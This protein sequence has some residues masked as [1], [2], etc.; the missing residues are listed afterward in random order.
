M[1]AAGLT[2]TLYMRK[3]CHL[4]EQAKADL[5]SLQAVVAHR[6]VEVDIETSP[7]LISK[8]ALEIPVVE[9]GPYHV[10]APFTRQELEVTLRAAADRKTHLEKLDAPRY[11]KA[12]ERAGKVTRSDRFSWWM[13]HHYM[14]VFNLFLF[15]Y[16]FLPFLAPVFMK[17][18]WEGG[19]KVIYKIYSPLCHQWGFRS[20]FLFGEQ[21]YYPHTEADIPGVISFESATGISDQSDPSRQQ[22]RLFEG[23]GVLGYK[24]AL[25]QRDVAIWGSMLLFGLVFVATGRRIPKIHWMVW[26][27][28]GL[29]PVGLDGIS[30][31]LSQLPVTAG[32]LGDI[33][34]YRESTPFLRSLTG[35]LFGLV[36]AWF[37][38]PMVEE[39]MADTRRLLAKQFAAK[40]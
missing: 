35:S 24:V 17:A 36:T 30:Q 26:L 34:P 33:L 31:L 19:A 22:A 27:I 5:A 8:Y 40:R 23:D 21:A 37:M 20:W 14:L 39:T 10:K 25:C 13:A 4:C 3:E 11:R 15:L 38:F 32:F 9:I 28:L 29:V 16:A 12:Q 6:L 2:V 18:G 1:D 7:D